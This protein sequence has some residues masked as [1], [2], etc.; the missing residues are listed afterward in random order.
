MPLTDQM[1]GE[2]GPVRR[3]L[4]A[5]RRRDARRLAATDDAPDRVE[6]GGVGLV[7]HVGTDLR[8]AIDPEHQLC[9]VVATD[10]DGVDI[11]IVA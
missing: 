10:G 7:E 9:E 5:Q 3:G 1:L 4:S 2:S 11:P 8:V 6:Y